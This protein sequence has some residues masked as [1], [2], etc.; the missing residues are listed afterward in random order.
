MSL[1][2]ECIDYFS[3]KAFRRILEGIYEKYRSLGRFGG[4][5][6]ILKPSMEERQALSRYLGKTFD[7]R[8]ALRLEVSDFESRLTDT[9]FEEISL[10]DIVEKVLNHKLVTNKQLEEIIT[11]ERKELLQVVSDGFCQDEIKAFIDEIDGNP[12]QYRTVYSK[13]DNKSLVKNELVNVCRAITRLPKEKRLSLPVF[14]ASITGDPHYF[15]YKTDTGNL[16]LRALAFLC[17]AEYP[18]RAEERAELLYQNGILI[19]ELSNFVLTNGLLAEAEEGENPIWTAAKEAAEPLIVTLFNLNRISRVYC[20]RNIVIAVENPSVFSS[21]IDKHPD[22][23]CVCVGGQPNIAVL[24]VLK[25]LAESGSK[26]Y[27]SGDFDP[28]GI[29][30]ADRLYRKIEGIEVFCMGVDFYKKALSDIKLEQSRLK[31]LDKIKCPQLIELCKEMHAV[32]KAGYQEQIIEDILSFVMGVTV[33][34][35]DY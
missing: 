19:D 23:P 32:A 8:E 2:E 9:K 28:E 27:Y 26:I 13:M 12:S 16:L 7:N 18:E 33:I 31:K 25:K 22:L 20:S 29:E 5:V 21:L 3:N 11:R 6:E 30:I 4:T 24:I 14:S 15:D 35:A 17:G 1:L 34:K 10:R